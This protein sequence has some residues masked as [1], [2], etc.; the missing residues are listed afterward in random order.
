MIFTQKQKKYFQYS[1]YTIII[2]IISLHPVSGIW[3]GIVFF[4]IGWAIPTITNCLL[5]YFLLLFFPEKLFK[6]L[7]FFIFV[8]LSFILG[9]NIRI[10]YIFTIF[11]SY[12]IP[13]INSIK[14]IH[15]LFNSPGPAYFNSGKLEFK[16][17]GH[18]KLK[19]SFFGS[20]TIGGDE[21]CM[22][23]YFKEPCNPLRERGWGIFD[24]LGA[25]GAN[26]INYR[27][28][29]IIPNNDGIV[30]YTTI[31]DVKGGNITVQSTF[32]KGLGYTDT[33]FD[34]G[35]GDRSHFKK[36]FWRYMFFNLINDNIWQKYL[37]RLEKTKVSDP[38][39]SLL[40]L[41]K[42]TYILP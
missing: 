20:V 14:I 25:I 22:C 31:K 16:I 8:L 18:I 42:E 11:Y 2:Y 41:K 24:K 1:L 21:G 6:L 39:E 17:D 19:K 23:L 13:E 30:V 10:P 26:S 15:P 38:L 28:D 7:K 3:G 5:A 27:F 12:H 4:I 37:S 34:H 33:S 36:Y 9:V 35:R 40:K 32:P 29:Q